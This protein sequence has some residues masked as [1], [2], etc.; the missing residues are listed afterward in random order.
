MKNDKKLETITLG[1]GCF[2]CLDA[3]YSCIEGV[4]SVVAGYAGGWLVNPTY[5]QVSNSETGHAEVVKITFDPAEISLEDI[6]H[7]FFTIHNPTTVDRQG[8]DIGPQYRS[9]ILYANARQKE[10]AQKIVEEI[11]QQK[12]YNSPIVT[13]IVELESFYPAEDYHQKYFEKNPTDAYCQ[14]VIEPK[15]AKIRQKY[16]KFYKS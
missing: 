10:M 6:L 11:S 15:I 2:W 4:Q 8:S 16:S 7:I 1:G 5:E 9:L 12:I 13:E 3:A 14:I